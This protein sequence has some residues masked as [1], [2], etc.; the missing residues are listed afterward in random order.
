MYGIKF[1]QLLFV[2]KVTHIEGKMRRISVIRSNVEEYTDCD[3][4]FGIRW[5]GYTPK[6][7]VCINFNII[8]I[9]KAHEVY[10]EHPILQSLQ[11]HCI[12][13]FV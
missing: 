9:L 2:V 12:K 3:L 6:N 8:F 7:L 1:I 11:E 5:S 10:M 4:R 13:I